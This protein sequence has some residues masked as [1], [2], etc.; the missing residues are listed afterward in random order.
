MKYLL[1]T[2]IEEGVL[3]YKD[4]VFKYYHKFNLSEAEAVAL[5]KLNELLKEHEGIINPKKFSKWMSMDIKATETLLESLMTKGYLRIKLIETDAGKEKET[6]DIDFFISKVIDHIQKKRA[7][8]NKGETHRWV[9]FI[10]DSLQKP[11]TPLDMEIVGKWLDEDQYTFEM[12]KEATL[13]VLK[14]KYTSVKAI[15]Q[16]LLKQ[17]EKVKAPPKKKEVLK[18]FHKLWDE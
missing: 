16:A 6:F 17:L 1:K 11:L 10:E 2:L 14:R 13:D 5:I 12:V 18:E 8:Q 7:D 4:L 15:D 9:E 3:D